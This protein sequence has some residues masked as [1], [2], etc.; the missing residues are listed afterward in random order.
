MERLDRSHPRN[1][2]LA[3]V[4]V[5]TSARLLQTCQPAV[6]VRGFVQPT[7]RPTPPPRVLNEDV[8]GSSPRRERAVVMLDWS[9]KAYRHCSHEGAALAERGATRPSTTSTSSITYY[10]AP[11]PKGEGPKSSRRSTSSLLAPSASSASRSWS[12]KALLLR[13]V[14]AV[15]DSVSVATTFKITG[16][17]GGRHLL[18][19]IRGG[20]EDPDL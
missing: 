2:S 15:F 19:V 5:S 16:Q 7:S 13:R 17:G 4:I 8:S 9:L 20:A 6:Q 1:L 18:L 12:R 11:K 3:D 14:D 10:S